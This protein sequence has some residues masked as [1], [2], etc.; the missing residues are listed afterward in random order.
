MLEN[1]DKVIDKND[2]IKSS[3]RD[4]THYTCKNE[5]DVIGAS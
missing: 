4:V 2:K 1:I 3:S 5:R